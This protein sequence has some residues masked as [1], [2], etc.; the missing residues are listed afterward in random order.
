MNDHLCMMVVH[1]R[2]T[3]TVI[4]TAPESGVQ[5]LGAENCA[6]FFSHKIQS[7]V[8]PNTH[9]LMCHHHFITHCYRLA[10]VTVTGR[11]YHFVWWWKLYRCWL[12]ACCAQSCCL[13]FFCWITFFVAVKKFR[14]VFT[15]LLIGILNA[16]KIEIPREQRNNRISQYNTS[17]W[18]TLFRVVAGAVAA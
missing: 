3:G 11:T 15:R 9:K 1:T 18:D 5:Q 6:G 16:E 8:R 17:L 7:I 14:Q 12:L 13:N 2:V 4:G 10:V